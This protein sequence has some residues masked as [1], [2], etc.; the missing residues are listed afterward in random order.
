MLQDIL[1]GFPQSTDE[2]VLIDNRT[3]DDAGVFKISAGTALVQTVDFLTPI[4]DDPYTFGAIAATNALSDVYAMGGTPITALNIA[5]FP[6]TRLDGSVLREILH[7]A[8]DKCAEAG[9]S[10]LGG[11]TIE[12]SEPKFGL[13]VTGT[14]RPDQIWSNAGATAGDVLMLTK[15]IGTGILATAC[16]KG[17]ISTEDYAEAVIS[18]QRLNVM[19]RAILNSG[20]INACTDITGFGLLGHLREMLVASKMDAELEAGAVPLFGGVLDLAERGIAPGGSE[21]NLAFV[22]DSCSFED[23]VSN[24]MRLVLADAQTS[25]G[26]LLSVSADV[27]DEAYACLL[28]EVSRDVAII[29]RTDGSGT[30]KIRI[31]SGSTSG[32]TLGTTT[33]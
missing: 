4:V 24:A 11:H 30:G 17:F 28:Q 25:G 33:K 9:V 15:P 18:M 26:L 19:P 2:R 16:K 6:S 10:V 31:I 21:K 7:G 29:G 1:S 27:A 32:S 3:S 8:A 5:C 23:N 13:A 12:D 20:W 14:I 22:A